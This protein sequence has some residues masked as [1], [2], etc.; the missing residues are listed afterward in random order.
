MNVK[1]LRTIPMPFPVRFALAVTLLLSCDAADRKLGARLAEASHRAAVV[2]GVVDL[3]KEADFSWDTFLLFR[4]YTSPEEIRRTLGF[5]W[6]S[7]AVEAIGQTDTFNLLVF[8]EG[9][10]VKRYAELPTKYEFVGAENISIP[11]ASA[12]FRASRISGG[13]RLKMVERYKTPHK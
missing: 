10:R 3:A 13:I 4:P 7:S 11:P 5:A 12:K 9:G 1:H 2:D 8:V 6:K